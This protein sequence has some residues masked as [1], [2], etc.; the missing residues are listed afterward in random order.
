MKDAVAQEIFQMFP[1]YTRGVVVARQL[2]NTGEYEKVSE[3][4]RNVE[5]HAVD[6]ENLQDIK[7]H[8]QISI[9][10]KA[11]S[12]FGA[13]PNKYYSSEFSRKKTFFIFNFFFSVFFFQNIFLRFIYLFDSIY[14]LNF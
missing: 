6:N 8:P 10:R 7:N 11:Y 2:D 13:N 3:L 9:W 5:I 1:N 4:L 14:C 12:E